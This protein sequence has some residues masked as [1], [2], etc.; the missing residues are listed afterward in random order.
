MHTSIRLRPTLFAGALILVLIGTARADDDRR[1]RA[2]LL[3]AYVQECGS[4]HAAF[5]PGLLPAESWQRQMNNLGRHYGAD[6]S[7]DAAT[8]R[9]IA[10]WLQLH[11]GSG[12]R[13]AEA[14]PQDRITLGR[15]FV[16]EHGEVPA[17]AWKRPAIGSAANCAA[18]HT[19]AAS[20]RYSERAVRIPQ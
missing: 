15:W 14:P 8:A 18:C 11:A 2:P 1:A 16:K 12:K 17:A 20:G 6:A 19:D 4:C 5:P 7:L 10:E 3:P 13:A 9:S